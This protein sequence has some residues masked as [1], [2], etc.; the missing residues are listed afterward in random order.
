MRAAK[1]DG[2]V[3]A[4]GQRG[5]N[6]WGERAAAIIRAAVLD[7]VDGRDVGPFV[8]VS[9][10]R[11]AAGLNISMRTLE[12]W[13]SPGDDRTFTWA[14]AFELLARE[15]ILPPAVRSRAIAG[16]LAEWGV[17]PSGAGLEQ[18]RDGKAGLSDVAVSAA[19]AVGDVCGAVRQA[20]DHAGPGGPVVTPHEAAHIAGHVVNAQRELAAVAE[21]A[22]AGAAEGTGQ[23]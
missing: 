12:H 16:V 21:T 2:R 13:L 14:A 11:I 3:S 9:R 20:T 5:A 8:A 22:A 15:D 1:R 18:L 7:A 10:A 4:A 23:R 6:G 17:L 19:G